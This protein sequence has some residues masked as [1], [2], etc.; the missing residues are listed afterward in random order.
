M[1]RSL[2]CIVLLSL[3]AAFSGCDTKIEQFDP[4]QV[5][6]MTLARS[7]AIPMDAALQDASEATDSLFGTPN[8][9]RWPTEFL[10]ESLADLVD[11]A[12]LVQAAG[13]VL[14]LQDGT[15][16]GLYRE[17]CAV[18]HGL[19]GSGNG[20]AS[21]VQNP[22]PRDFR[23][24]LFK[25]KSTARSE[26]PTRDDLIERIRHGI[27]GTAMPAYPLIS[28]DEL[29]AIV[30]YVIYLSIRGE[31]ERDLLSAAVDEMG[32][33]EEVPEDELRLKVPAS[34]GEDSLTEGNEVTLEIL[35]EVAQEWADAEQYVVEVPSPTVAKPTE[36]ELT[37]S[38]ERGRK[39]FHGQIANCVGCHDEDG[40]GQTITLDY[41]DWSK[42]Y[43]SRIGLTPSDSVDMKPFLDAGA[44]MPRQI[45]PRTLKDGIFHGGGDAET[46]YRRI[47]QG[48]AGT[49][50]PGIEVVA[51][52]S[53][54]GLTV[55][56]VWNLIRY[57][58]SF[59]S[60]ENQETANESR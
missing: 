55:D 49:P 59:A 41:D 39:L 22:Y 56:Q 20:P 31:V 35:N 7:R 18:C 2:C 30:D 48:I 17:H 58:Q 27:A 53:H 44:M 42:E 37:E 15:Q 40:L 12:R 46:L 11:S 32:Y 9:P 10:D 23:H 57:V 21:M 24:G 43:S 33:E 47:V 54:Q 52:E 19:S 3:V 45:K 14:S 28:N 1:F 4:N 26:R 60:D 50:M 6:S 13:P 36:S 5:Y 51:I 38:I 8:D 34:V 25:W 16:Q 29:D